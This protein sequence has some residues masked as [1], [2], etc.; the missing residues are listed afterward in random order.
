MDALATNGNGAHAAPTENESKAAQV[1]ADVLTRKGFLVELTCSRWSGRARLTEAD[2]GLEGL[3]DEDLHHLGR[4]QLVPGEELAKIS[5]IETRA[6]QRLGHASYAFPVGGARFVPATV[7]G[8]LLADLSKIK[9][10]FDAAVGEF[11]TSYE[12]FSAEMRQRWA[13][14]AQRVKEELGKDDEWR[15]AFAARLSASYPPVEKV[16]ESFLIEWSLF[17]FALPKD[18]KAQLVSAEDALQASRLAEEAR[19]KLEEKIA[20]FVGEAALELRRRAGEMCAH[21]AAQVKKSGD[22]VT[23]RTLQPLRELIEQFRALDFTGDDGFASDLD[24]LQ[25]EWLGGKAN[26]TAKQA[27]ESADYRDG[28]SSAL[29]TMATKAVAESERAAAEALER[30]LKFG[31]AGRQVAL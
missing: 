10:D 19:A 4:R 16:R 15:D 28:L 5:K 30:F 3:T 1:V 6:R 9:G 21:V 14:N 11:C 7:L 12:K 2:L 22:K 20:G 18:I 31:G 17:Q 25:A 27:R 13:A 8:N 24:A 29:E 23:E 26:G